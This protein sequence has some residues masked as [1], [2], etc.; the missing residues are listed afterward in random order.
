MC[1]SRQHQHA[2]GWW[3]TSNG[4]L[5]WQRAFGII[6]VSHCVRRMIKTHIYMIKI[7]FAMGISQYNDGWLSARDMDSSYSTLCCRRSMR[8]SLWRLL[9]PECIHNKRLAVLCTCIKVNNIID[10]CDKD[11]FSWVR[12]VNPFVARRA[13]VGVIPIVCHL[14][15]KQNTPLSLF[16]ASEVSQ[17]RISQYESWLTRKSWHSSFFIHIDRIRFWFIQNSHTKP[18]LLWWINMLTIPP[19]S[20]VLHLFSSSASLVEKD[21]LLYAMRSA[22]RFKTISL[23]CTQIR[24]TNGVDRSMPSDA[25]AVYFGSIILIPTNQLPH[26][27]ALRRALFQRN[28][29]AQ[30]SNDN[31]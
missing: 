10:K 28:E 6:R 2:A 11:E 5:W 31:N 14:K 17:L 25:R 30:S 18:E 27:F 13:N 7:V 1:D 21:Y 24:M 8:V 26:C 3:R 9:V 4:F 20:C 23:E 16:C 15:Q 22:K 29:H 19:Y 12:P